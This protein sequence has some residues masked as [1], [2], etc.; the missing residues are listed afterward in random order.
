MERW[1]NFFIAGVPKAGTTSLYH[2][3]KDI[4]GIYMSPEK[5][6]N[7]FSVKTVPEDHPMIPIRNKKKYLDLFKNVK[8]E[9][10]IGEATP[11]YLGDPD[12]PKL[13]HEV[14]PEAKILIS[15]RNPVQR[16]FSHY[17]MLKGVGRVKISFH[18]LIQKEIKHEYDYGKFRIPL[19]TS[20]YSNNVKRFIN[21]FGKEQVKII[22]FEDLITEP[23]H[24]LSEI[25]KFLDIN[26][27]LA[28][29]DA[30]QHN[31]SSIARGEI[32]QKILTNMRV[33]KLAKSGFIPNSIRGILRNKILMTK[34][35]KQKMDDADRYFLEKF[36]LDDVQELKKL[37]DTKIPW[38]GF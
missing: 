11:D 12:A 38:T 19:E 10:I 8:N 16:L 23:N 9:K 27:S 24:V 31:P 25:L 37:L 7:Y 2:Y 18:E 32:S 14:S 17:L 4:P 21:I 20:F 28:N 29:F 30:K 3:L 5:E 13:I 33:R 6:P 35:T 1:P 26:Y 15:L 22:F 34:Q 36:Y